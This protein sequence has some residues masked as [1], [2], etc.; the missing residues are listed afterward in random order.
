MDYVITL[1]EK[2]KKTLERTIRDEDLMHKNMKQAT[3]Q[4]KNISEI[5]KVLK[6]LKAKTRSVHGTSGN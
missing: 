5:K 4:L 3:S 2:E 6:I 1:L